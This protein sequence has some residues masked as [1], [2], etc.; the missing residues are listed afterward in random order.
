VLSRPMD[1]SQSGLEQAGFSGWVPFS[2]LGTANVPAD[3]GVYVVLRPDNTTPLFLPVSPA[4]WFKGKDPSVPI[5]DLEKSWV[6]DASLLYV[7]K[8]NGGRDG[9]R[10]LRTRLDEY[11]RYG[12]GTPVAHRGGRYV[13]QLA[14]SDDLL[15]GW[16]TT[17]D[18]IARELERNMIAEFKAMHSKRPFANLRG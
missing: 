6:P 12:A 18:G 8:A 1:W 15:V 7:G 17:A 4:G 10:G 16:K 13:W 3:P 11:R 9:R 2:A 5:A 14:D